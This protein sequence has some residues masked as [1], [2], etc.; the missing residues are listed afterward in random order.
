MTTT[1][2]LSLLLVTGGA[3]AG[4][5]Q[6]APVD[7][8]EPVI[9]PR[10]VKLSFD[11]QRVVRLEDATRFAVTCPEGAA[12][13]WIASKAKLWWKIAP[14]VSEGQATLPSADEGYSIVAEP[15]SVAIAAR[16]LQGVRYAMM[17]LRQAAE[18]CP[19]GF[20]EEKYWLAALR[21]EDVP[22][23]MFRGIHLCCFPETSAEYVERQ[24]RLAA[25]YKYNYAV[26][27]SWG[28]FKSERFPFLAYA[29]SWL[30]P[31]E[32]RRLAT[33]AKDL[34]L[35][36]VPQFN[37]FGHAAGARFC[38]GKHVTLDY[39]PQY[40][41]LFEP[42]GGWNWCLSNPE[43]LRVHRELLAEM[44]AAFLNPPFVHIGCD[45][46][47]RP[48]CARCRAAGPYERLFVGHVTAI[49]DFL[50]SR[51][52]RTMM[53]HDMLVDHDDV[54]WKG[55]GFYA[56]GT[57]EIA[58]ILRTSFPKDVVICDWYYGKNPAD[59]D[60]PTL[61]HFKELGFDVL[62]CP[63]TDED[64]EASRIASQAGFVR[65]NGLFG[66]LQTVWNR[67]AYERFAV[68]VERSAAAAWGTS[69]PP[70]F[71][72]EMGGAPIPR[73]FA[74]HWQQVGWDMGAKS[75]RETGYVDSQVTR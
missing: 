50:R 51:G 25:Y 5:A 33:L 63:W 27:E 69:A 68:T 62:S 30:T 34:G 53:W 35:T 29:D 41:S 56:N 16:T 61:R 59:G 49:A 42:G 36:L 43:T 71:T 11:A 66:I 23:M 70:K 74:T 22:A 26:I 57:P 64:G 18:P 13:D 37:V 17:T 28:M 45:E 20:G 75:Y 21:V 38:S 47:N 55:K 54:R 60:Y 2:L 3:F 58:E 65:R 15:G 40:Q 7:F 48:S 1:V 19:A 9:V 24:I 73:P 4:V 32:A 14:I 67:F 8:R 12:R 39:H 72:P 52:A 46:A 44:H 31:A 10:P 6:P